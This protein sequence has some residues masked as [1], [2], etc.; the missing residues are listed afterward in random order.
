MCSRPCVRSRAS[1][2]PPED[3]LDSE[4]TP[5]KYRN[6]RT[7]VDGITFASRREANRYVEL[8][9]ELLTS[10]IEELE[11]QKAFSLDVNGIHICDYVADFVYRRSGREIVEDAKGPRLE[12][13]KLK[14]A[15]MK[16][17]LGID[18]VEV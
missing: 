4:G 5:S 11:L 2:T 12:L 17:I 8:R 13:F 10:E 14:K 7:T 1:E 18:V 16:A 15:L 6:V 9:I 3:S